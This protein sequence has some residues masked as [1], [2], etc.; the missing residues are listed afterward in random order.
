MQNPFL[1]TTLWALFLAL[2]VQTK[3][4]AQ[5][6]KLDFKVEKNSAIFGLAPSGDDGFLMI[7]GQQLIAKKAKKNVMRFDANLKP[8]W[9]APAVISGVSTANQSNFLSMVEG[10]NSEIEILSYSSPTDGQTVNYIFGAE[11]FVQIL[12]DGTVNEKETGIPKKEWRD[13]LAAVFVDAHGLNVLTLTGD[14]DFP[15]EEMN[16]YC[17]AHNGLALKKRTIKLPRPEFIVKKS[18]LGWRLNEVSESGLYFYLVSGRMKKKGE[19][20][21]LLT[22]H[23]IHV[24]QEARAG[25]EIILD[26]GIKEENFMPIDFQQNKYPAMSVYLPRLAEL[27]FSS[28]GKRTYWVLN[29]NALMGIK[30]DA[31]SNRIYTATAESNELLEK[32]GG[33]GLH[34]PQVETI[35]LRSFDLA[36]NKISEAQLKPNSPKRKMADDFTYTA[37]SLEIIPLPN[38]EGVVCKFFSNGNGAI[39]AVNDRGEQVVDKKFKPYAYKK[40]TEQHYIDVYASKRYFS[41]KDFQASAYAAV[42]KTAVEK[43]FAKLDEGFQR[44]AQ[45]RS[46]KNFELLAFSDQKAKVIRLSAFPKN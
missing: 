41:M 17:Y 16:W 13:E 1:K 20:L 23:I 18:E 32:R 43:N 14:E 36:G 31:A 42:E 12:P 21:P 33:L 10:E 15:T 38:A 25:K 27:R 44:K 9:K 37:H 24:D 11:Q 22:C 19:S 39:W 4:V 34:D 35:G 29:V 40:M 46:M 2:F 28:N 6:P 26:L 45:F 3:I 30:I 5:D 8:V 7:Y